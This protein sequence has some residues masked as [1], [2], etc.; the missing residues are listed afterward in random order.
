MAAIPTDNKP[1]AAF[2]VS[3]FGNQENVF[4]NPQVKTHPFYL[5][6]FQNKKWNLV[7]APPLHLCP[8]EAA[9][10]RPWFQERVRRN[11]YPVTTNYW[12]S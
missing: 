8:P 11:S 12:T 6:Y 3:N 9:S 7:A 5:I 1:V 10:G 2:L 4:Q